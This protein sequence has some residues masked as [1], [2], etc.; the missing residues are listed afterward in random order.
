MNDEVLKIKKNRQYKLL[1]FIFTSI[2]ITSLLFF[3]DEGYY[4]FN[5]TKKLL[6]W[7]IFSFYGIPIFLFQYSIFKLLPNDLIPFL[8]YFISVVI[9]SITGTIVVILLFY[10]TA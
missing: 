6:N 5:W 1:I 8:K 2:I 3:I 4:N 10:L 9:G 7:I